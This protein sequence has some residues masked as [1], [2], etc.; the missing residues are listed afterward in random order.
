MWVWSEGLQVPNEDRGRSR[1]G[2]DQWLKVVIG[3]A[4]L[5]VTVPQHMC[6]VFPSG[7]LAFRRSNCPCR[8]L[9]LHS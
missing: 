3:I 7:W 1:R 5:E 6:F 9:T 2:Q 4:C 8:I